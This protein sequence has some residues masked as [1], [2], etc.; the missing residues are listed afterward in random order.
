VLTPEAGEAVIEAL[1]KAARKIKVDPDVA[2][3]EMLFKSVIA[4]TL[5][6][7]EEKNS[8]SP[9]SGIS[10]PKQSA[11]T[12]SSGKTSQSSAPAT[13]GEDSGLNSSASDSPAPE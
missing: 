7:D 6:G 13:S 5:T 4:F 11:S 2:V 9:L 10:S 3:R 1:A 12:Q 8:S